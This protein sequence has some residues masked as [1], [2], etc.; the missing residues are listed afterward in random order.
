MSS[1]ERESV[2]TKIAGPLGHFALFDPFRFLEVEVEDI[3]HIAIFV[4]RVLVVTSKQNK[5]PLPPDMNQ[6]AVLDAFGPIFELRE[7]REH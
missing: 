5:L 6:T 3:D 4:V 7:Y 2:L 1:G